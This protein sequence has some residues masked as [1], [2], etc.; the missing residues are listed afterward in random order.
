MF[1]GIGTSL[2]LFFLLFLIGFGELGWL[3]FVL[4][5]TVVW[6]RRLFPGRA[7]AIPVL[8]GGGILF[9]HL[10]GYKFYGSPRLYD[11]RPVLEQAW[12]L[13]HLEAPNVMVATDGSRHPVPGVVLLDGIDRI[14]ADEQPR[15]FDRARE[16]LRFAKT[17]DGYVAEKRNEYWCGN[18]WFPHFFPR[19]LPSHREAGMA[20]VFRYH[21]ARPSARALDPTLS[22]IPSE[23]T[24]TGTEAAKAKR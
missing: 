3:A 11:N 17:A 6:A 18:T 4:L 12:T 15:M 8:V 19:R 23:S 7:S 5:W 21:V 24:R 13:D 20:E 1:K 22:P 10:V 16:P 2:G 9:L 14:P